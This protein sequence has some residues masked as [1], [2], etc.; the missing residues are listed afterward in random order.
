MPLRAKQGECNNPGSR[1]L[2]NIWTVTRTKLGRAPSIVDQRY[3]T[4]HYDD[5]GNRKAR[6]AGV[7]HLRSKTIPIPRYSQQGGKYMLGE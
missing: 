3:C 7:S 2:V 5:R 6:P 1:G 4:V